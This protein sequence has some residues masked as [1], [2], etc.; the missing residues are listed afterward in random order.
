MAPSV[1]YF[2]HRIDKDGLHPTENMVKC[3]KEAATPK[4]VTELKA[5]LRL[6]NYY[7]RFLPH[8][9]TKLAPMYHLLQK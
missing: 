1:E 4:N 8:L 5:F 2:G 7:E 6:M 3:I 9:A